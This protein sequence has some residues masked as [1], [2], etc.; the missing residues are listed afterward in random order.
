MKKSATFILALGL[1]LVLAG[2]GNSNT[3]QSEAPANSETSA[4]VSQ[5]AAG[6]AG[7]TAD[8][9]PQAGDFKAE[10]PVLLT[11]GGQSADAAMV[12]TMLEKSGIATTADNVATADA[13]GENKTLV[14]AVGGSSKGLGAAGIDANGEVDRLNALI[15]AAKD[16]GVKIIAMHIGGEAR[17]GELS[18]KF[19]APVFEHADYAIVVSAGDQ[20]GMMQKIA[21]DKGYTLTLIEKITDAIPALEAVLK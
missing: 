1:S 14:V 11:S 6:E 5:T 3:T 21:K 9:Q 15:S 18:D 12:K 2:C 8:A 10:Q 16:K 13:L 20:D 17:R 19:I 7:S 4:A